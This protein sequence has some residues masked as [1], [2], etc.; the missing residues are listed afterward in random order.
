M[1]W[2]HWLCALVALSFADALRLEPRGVELQRRARPR[3]A[4]V[5][6]RLRGGALAAPADAPAVTEILRTALKSALRGGL[7][8]AAAAAVQVLVLM[9]LRTLTNYQYRYGG[10][11]RGA[12]TTL[13]AEG[14]AR[15]LYRG[16][17]F[18][19][20]QNPLSKFGAVAANEAVLTLG[21]A[22][23]LDGA[24]AASAFAFWN[25]L[26]ALAASAWRVLIMPVDLCKTLL[27]V[28]GTK[29]FAALRERVLRE[30][31]WFSLYEGAAAQAA[32]TI[33]AHFPW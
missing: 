13:W 3:R 27:Q 5:A 20:V 33:C 17:A 31:A 21:R 8:G 11:F 6:L 15:R 16:T 10:T 1:N 28:D 2:R 32:V 14:G 24:S 25:L 23:T 18:A 12:F 4:A 29:G 7:P 22:L 26:G 9:W 19:L 30:R